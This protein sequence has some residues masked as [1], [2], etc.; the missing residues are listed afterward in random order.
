MDILWC[1]SCTIEQ[2]LSPDVIPSPMHGDKQAVK[3]F[4]QR[5]LYVILSWSLH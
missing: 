3:K 2:V 1:S 5:G 4:N